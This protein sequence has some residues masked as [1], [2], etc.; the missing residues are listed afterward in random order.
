MSRRYRGLRAELSTILAVDEFAQRPLQQDLPPPNEPISSHL[1]NLILR[2]TNH[3]DEARTVYAYLPAIILRIFGFAPGQGWLETCSEL[4]SR[5]RDALVSIVLPD[6]PLHTFCKEHTRPRSTKIDFGHDMRFEFARRNLPPL[7]NA[8]LD[9][10]RIPTPGSRSYLAPLLASSLRNKADDVIFLS[11]LDYFVICMIASP[12]QKFVNAPG[13]SSVKIPKRSR[14]IPSLR[15]QY[16]QVITAYAALRSANASVDSDDIF[17]LA[18]L[19]YLFIPWITA[20][21]SNLPYL[22]TSAADAVA[23]LLLALAPTSPKDLDLDLETDDSTLGNHYMVDIHLFTNCG[24]LYRLTASMLE[25]LFSNFDASAPIFPLNSYIRVLAMLIAPWR[26]SVR[27]TVSLM[28]LPKPKPSK[29]KRPSRT[30]MAALSSTLSSINAHLPS[31]ASPGNATA[32]RDSEWRE[33][34]RSR[35][36]LIDKH[37]LRTAVVLAAN[38]HVASVADGSRVMAL[39]ADAAQGARLYSITLPN[40]D[41]DRLEELQL[42]LDALRGQRSRLQRKNGSREKNFIPILASNLG[43]KTKNGGVFSGISEMVGVGSAQVLSQVNGESLST[44]KRRLKDFKENWMG[45]GRSQEVPFIGSV[46]DRPIAGNESE[47]M[48][49]FAYWIALRLE[50]RLG[51]LPNTRFLGQYWVW[52]MTAIIFVVS[53]VTK[54]VVSSLG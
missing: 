33:Q 51:Y 29:G 35:Q 28:L 31:S 40:D 13:S 43:D 52:I 39:L 4:P 2:A 12:T 21:P 1:A 9:S 42:C 24:V 22:S 18:C 46:W 48:V 54:R 53:W 23:S 16:N 20:L 30:S 47:M 3:P 27:S 32:V 19:D 44:T 10:D 8:A 26:Q 38:M 41:P 49:I 6:G 34:L 25:N 36:T 50:P 5:D 11:P 45:R 17:I 14:S 7:T 15:A 37:L